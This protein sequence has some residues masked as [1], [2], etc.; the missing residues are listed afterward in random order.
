M[1]SID[2]D[3]VRKQIKDMTDTIDK[4]DSA[5]LKNVRAGLSKAAGIVVRSAKQNVRR[6]RSVI[7]GRLLNSITFWLEEEQADEKIFKVFV[8]TNV[9]DNGFYYG[10]AV[11]FGTSRSREKPYLRPAIESNRTE[12]KRIIEETLKASEKQSEEQPEGGE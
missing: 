11:E 10:A 7:T 5:A 8:G 1:I 9:N 12:V 6:N 3:S 2:M 4:A